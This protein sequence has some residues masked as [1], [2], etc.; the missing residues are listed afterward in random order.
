MALD[1]GGWSKPRFDR[2][3]PGKDPGNYCI[4]GWVVWSGWVQKILPPLGFTLWTVQPVASRYTMYTN[5]GPHSHTCTPT[6]CLYGMHRDNFTFTF[7]FTLSHIQYFI[8][9]FSAYYCG[10]I[11][12]SIEYWALFYQNVFALF[13]LSLVIFVCNF[14]HLSRHQA[15]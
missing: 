5:P 1:G 6:V 15:C 10:V 2:F 4:K 13:C 12:S 7:T 3:T 8:V 9:H 14:L 11:F